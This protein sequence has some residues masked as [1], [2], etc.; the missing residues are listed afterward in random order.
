MTKHCQYNNGS[1]PILVGE[2][3]IIFVPISVFL[4]EFLFVVKMEIINWEI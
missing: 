3:V 4:E 1:L 2:G